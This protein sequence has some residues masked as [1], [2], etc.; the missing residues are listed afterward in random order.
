MLIYSSLLISAPPQKSGKRQTKSMGSNLEQVEKYSAMNYSP[1]PDT[2]G[3][4]GAAENEGVMQ[5]SKTSSTSSSTSNKTN[6]LQNQ[7]QV[8]LAA[9]PLS[10][11]LLTFDSM[12]YVSEFWIRSQMLKF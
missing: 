3:G 11:D 5:R 8:I 10:F 1:R 4:V 2:G 7:N 12:L 9:L 6:H